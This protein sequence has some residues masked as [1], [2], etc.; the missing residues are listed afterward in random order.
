MVEIGS[1]TLVDGIIDEYPNLQ[2]VK[3]IE[4]GVK[5]TNRLL[6]TD[7]DRKQVQ[8]LLESIEF[9]VDPVDNN[10]DRLKVTPPSF[11]VD[12]SRREDLMEEVAR[13]SGYNN[14]PTTFP[15][16]P[17]EGR[18]PDHRIRLRNQIKGLM[19]GLGFT[20]AIA[21]SFVAEASCDRLQ[22]KEDDPRRS[23]IHILN[24]LTED[25]AVMRTSLVPG[26]L[27]TMHHQYGPADQKLKSF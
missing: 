20:E 12:V 1:G 7:L 27:E 23:M 21:Y 26:I 6:G 25:Q 14:I 15:A 4:L 3:D 2:T 24:P 11:R 19:S 9:K 18:R 5:R 13:L 16:M 17:A 8:G 22:L 10:G